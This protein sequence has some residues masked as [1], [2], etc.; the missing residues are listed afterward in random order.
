ML[1]S[2]DGF[3]VAAIL[4][5]AG[6]SLKAVF[7]IVPR[8]P[9]LGGEN[10][11]A[12]TDCAKVIVVCANESDCKVSHVAL[13]A[14]GVIDRMGQIAKTSFRRIIV[15]TPDGDDDR[16]GRPFMR[17]YPIAA[18]KPRKKKN[19]RAGEREDSATPQRATGSCDGIVE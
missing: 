18:R 12:A 10:S 14:I 16:F 2:V 13:Y 8:S 3:N 9:R 19:R 11:P 6:R 4:Q 7:C 1:E 5:N 15:S 17:A